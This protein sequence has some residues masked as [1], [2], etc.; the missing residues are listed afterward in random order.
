MKPSS[1]YL[2]KSRADAEAE[3]RGEMET[4]ARH[5]AALLAL[6]KSKGLII[7]HIY[8]EIVSGD[9]IAERPEVQKLLQDVT[10]EKW[11]NVLV[12][13]IDRLA[14]GDTIDQ[15][16]VS[17]TFQY[18]NTKIITPQK[19]YDPNNEFD[20]EYFE[21]GLFMARREYKVINR[22]LQR[23]REASVLE[24]KYVAS[25][26]PYGYDR[27]K[28][29][30]DKGYTL[31]PNEDEAN[32]VKL[33]FELY[34]IGK[35]DTDGNYERIGVSKIVNYLNNL[36][37]KPKRRDTWV[38]A[39]IRDILI[40][41]V[42]IGKI[43]WNWR[44]V[45]KKIENGTKTFERPRTEKDSY[46]LV[47]GLH[48][49]IISEETWNLAQEYMKLN[50]PRPIQISRT[51]QNPLSGLV[52]CEKCGRRMARRPNGKYNDLLMC[53][54]TDCKNV[55]SD[56]SVVEKRV[57]DSLHDWIVQYEMAWKAEKNTSHSKGRRIKEDSIK[58]I[59]KNLSAC[60][61]KLDSVYDFLEQGIYTPEVFIERS[62]RLKTEIETLQSQKDILEN[63]ILN[64]QKLLEQHNALIPKV[65]HLLEIYWT[66]D[67]P[68]HKNDTLKE[69][70]DK[71]TYIKDAKSGRNMP[72]DNFSLTL[73]P[74]LP[75]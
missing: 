33:I 4:L 21:F 17:Q 7:G 43:R 40:N 11:D 62:E 71:I 55:A 75:K 12:M 68:K 19:A 50:P 51:V 16:I 29:E 36:G 8:R 57:I 48:S 54:Y 22:R 38:P 46:I 58:Q 1:I 24:G 25:R 74:K 67:T 3:Q 59:E 61:K 28:L 49:P 60:K 44:P 13:D 30:N 2:R 39:S 32:I 41:P 65:K 35:P 45:K 31:K 64:E 20:E 14:R 26:P 73:Y 70:I 5:E 37:I 6:A 69:V 27:C 34:T 56:L 42:Y 47:D 66:L 23:G 72:K 52:V 15:G 18:S 9:S 10:D 53:P 63:E